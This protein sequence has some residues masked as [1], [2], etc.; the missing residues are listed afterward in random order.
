MP[1]IVA[2][3]TAHDAWSKLQ[4]LYA[5]RLCTR[6]VQLKEE[7]TLIHRESRLVSEYLHAIKVLV[8]E[9]VV[10]ESPISVDDITLYVL[11]GFGPEYREIAAPIWAHKT[12]L[13]FE[14]LHDMLVGYESYLQCVD[15]SNVVL[16]ATANSTQH[17]T[18]ASTFNSNQCSSP[19]STGQRR[20]KS[21]CNNHKKQSGKPQIVC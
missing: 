14:K 10:I 17:R 16:V 7:L 21:G 13:T 19:G 3:T 9:L 18:S 15:V 5:N 12:S 20:S 4:Q 8:D 2:F 1:L 11:N 6:V